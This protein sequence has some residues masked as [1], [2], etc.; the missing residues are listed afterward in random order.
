VVPESFGYHAPATIDEALALLREHGDDAKLLAGGHSLLPAMKLRLAAPAQ[1]IDLR[2]L[3]GELRY[4]RDDGDHL[5]IG[6][7]TTHSELVAAPELAASAPLLAEAAATIGDVQVRNMGTLGGSLAHAD[8]AGDLPAAVLAAGATLV[9]RGP[10]GERTLPADAFFLGFFET[11]LEPDEIL[12]EVR[13]PRELGGSSYQK[14]AHPASGYAV[15][16]VGALLERDGERV[17]ACRVGVTGL[18]GEAYRAEAVEGALLGRAFDAA[19]AAEA[20]AL[21]ADGAE[22]LGDPFASEE[23]RSHLAVVTCRRALQTAWERAS[24]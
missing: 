11:A 2:R 10:G 16:G 17:S 6:A 14:F 13:V 1:L 7:L 4:L 24:D 20:A 18:S 19:L 9:L 23:F 5:A 15:V 21:V 22:P 3:Q 12:T 8:P